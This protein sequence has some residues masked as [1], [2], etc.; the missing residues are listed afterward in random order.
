MNKKHALSTNKSCRLVKRLSN[1]VSL[2]QCDGTVTYA[3]R[4]AYSSVTSTRS[5]TLSGEPRIDINSAHSTVDAVV[6][7]FA[8][9]SEAEINFS[10]LPMHWLRGGKLSL[11]YGE[12]PVGVA[13]INVKNAQT[14]QVYEFYNVDRDIFSSFR[15]ILK[16]GP[17]I[18]LYLVLA[19]A[20]I[21]MGVSFS[22]RQETLVVVL[23]SVFWLFAALVILI[24][25][26]E[27]QK[28]KDLRHALYHTD[29]LP[30]REGEKA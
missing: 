14:G 29:F 27:T 17:K 15:D 4:E 26:W 21:W 3:D 16:T 1:E 12:G 20:V 6:V 18:L 25:N 2:Y 9:G 24:F 23:T 19:F 30:Y 11:I 5:K 8:D 13:L 28:T 7:Q 22:V 10:N